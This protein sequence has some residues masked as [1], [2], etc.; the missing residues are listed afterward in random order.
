MPVQAQ[1]VESLP[2]IDEQKLQAIRDLGEPDDA[3]GFFRDLVGVFFQRVP[4]LLTDIESALSRGD[5]IHLERSA[6]ALKGTAGHLGAVWM[7]K[8][9][10]NLE[11]MGRQRTIQSASGLLTELK[12]VY[13]LT[14]QVLET[15]WL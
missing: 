5:P 6:H 2:L 4:G 1:T 12:Q 14:R 13:P 9:A 7:M 8:L 11:T 15:N 3:D 10:E